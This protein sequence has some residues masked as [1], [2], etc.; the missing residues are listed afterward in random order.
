MQYLKGES[1]AC[2]SFR[3]KGYILKVQ[4]AIE[5]ELPSDNM[6]MSCYVLHLTGANHLR[7]WYA[8]SYT[9]RL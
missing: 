5:D 7:N 6:P 4:I 1:S 2:T 3:Q 9:K 8:P